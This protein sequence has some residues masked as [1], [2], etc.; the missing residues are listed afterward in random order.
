MTNL[1]KIKNLHKNNGSRDKVVKSQEIY[2]D[3]IASQ[4]PLG[5]YPTWVGGCTEGQQATRLR[6]TKKYSQLLTAIGNRT[7]GKE[8]AVDRMIG[9][10]FVYDTTTWTTTT[11]AP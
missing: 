7:S 4:F 8:C 11:Y 10:T 5:S 1:A 9:T 6:K 3:L 2:E